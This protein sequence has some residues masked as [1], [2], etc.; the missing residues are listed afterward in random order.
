MA[1]AF[2]QTLAVGIA[3]RYPNC[4]LECV[5]SIASSDNVGIRL[6]NLTCGKKPYPVSVIIHVPLDMSGL[7]FD[8]SLIGHVNSRIIKYFGA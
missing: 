4:C 8:V 5:T 3:K 2:I 1:S 7:T 6:A